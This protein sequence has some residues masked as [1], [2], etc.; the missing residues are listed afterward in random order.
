[1][2]NTTSKLLSAL[3]IIYSHFAFSQITFSSDKYGV[4]VSRRLILC[5]QFQTPVPLGTTV[6]IF[7]KTYTLSSP[8]NSISLGD[9][10]T[11]TASGN[12]YTIVF[13]DIPI[14]KIS[15]S[16]IEDINL[17][18]EINGEISI[19]DQEDPY[20]SKMK[21][22][23]RGASSAT[24][25][26]KSYRVQLKSDDW[27]SNKDT[28]LFGLRE[29][30]R[31]LMLAM[32][33][34][35]LRLNNKVSHDLWMRM[36]KL[37]YQNLE[38]EA[39]SSIRSLYVEAFINNKYNG[40]YLFTEDTDRKQYKLKK[41]KSD[42]TIRGELYKA[43]THGATQFLS[44]PAKSPLSSDVW[45]GWEMK[46]PDED[47]FDWTNLYDFTDF[48]RNSSNAN[49][50][51]QIG[52]KLK[53]DNA[54]DYFIFLNMVRGT[55]NDGKNTFLAKYDTGEPYFYGVWDLDGT[56]GYYYTGHVQNV[57]N[58]IMSN[59]L[60]DRLISLN[61]QE[62]KNKLATRWFS[63][64]DNTLSIDS[65]H[66]NVDLQYNRLLV[67]K[68]YE[69][70]YSKWS[71]SYTHTNEVDYLKDWMVRRVAWLDNYF[72]NWVTSCNAP[73]VSLNPVNFTNGDAVTLSSLGCDGVVKWHETVSS[74]SHVYKG[75]DITIPGIYNP[76]S[77]FASCTVGTCV[78][79]TRTEVIINPNCSDLDLAYN[80]NTLVGSV[81]KTTETISSKAASL[82]N[83]EFSAGKSITLHPGFTV[84]D[85]I[86]F[87]AKIGGCP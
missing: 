28:T 50:I 71:Q 15:V 52:A 47:T 87:L 26:K 17:E 75:K 58:D 49:F 83:T 36:H 51:S 23:V 44:L 53:L 19:L 59:F 74:T 24:L 78:S 57:V 37:Y 79:S 46:Y 66:Y 42:G 67:N 70:E 62:F 39:V 12:S 35:R 65:L 40:V 22:K 56:L 61:P 84:D 8:I 76:T 31:W 4:D 14:V 68:V 21:I 81:Y 5:N 33:N 3:L 73:T 41:T 48:V 77:Y 85:G 82:G 10:L 9:K 60:F 80:D 27:S 54:M 63:L 38:P 55:D 30:K 2:N 34:E 13:T 43:D 11:A 69:R 45:G 86:V 6:L 64:R 18:T 32:H 7:D 25:A 1:M 72:N 20:N 16:D 29:D